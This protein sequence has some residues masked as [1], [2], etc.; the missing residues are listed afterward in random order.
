M[1]EMATV[2]V[3][4]G[5]DHIIEVATQEWVER[6]GELGPGV[7]SAW[8]SAD[9]IEIP[10]TTLSESTEGWRLIFEVPNGCYEID[11]LAMEPGDTI[12]LKPSPGR[13]LRACEQHP[14]YEAAYL[15][16]TVR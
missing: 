1:S 6:T 5:D 2:L 7:I 11:I 16:D 10:I 3:V 9:T 4:D 8:D 15:V 13:L 14:Q 12:T